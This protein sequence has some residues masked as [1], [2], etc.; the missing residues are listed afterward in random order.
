MTP[1]MIYPQAV[2]IGLAVWL[3]LGAVVAAAP[4]D[5][6][7]RPPGPPNSGGEATCSASTPLMLV[8]T[9]PSTAAETAAL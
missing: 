4:G 7:A 6:F 5:D 2:G 3:A 1:S 9:S 8:P